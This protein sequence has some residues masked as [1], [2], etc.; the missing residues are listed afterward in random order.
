[1]TIIF[2]FGH[3]ELHSVS[4]FSATDTFNLCLNLPSSSQFID[5]AFSCL[6]F[7]Q[8]MLTLKLFSQNSFKNI[9]HCLKNKT[10]IPLHLLH[11]SFL[12]LVRKMNLTISSSLYRLLII[13]LIAWSLPF[14]EKLLFLKAFGYHLWGL[15]SSPEITLGLLFAA[16]LVGFTIF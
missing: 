8:T 4:K 12:L 13:L 2:E 7:L 14:F 5:L 1:M 16:S 9:S 6:H 15:F 11:F 3:T 10:K